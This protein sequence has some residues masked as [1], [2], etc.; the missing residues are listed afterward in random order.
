MKQKK[1]YIKNIDYFKE[2]FFKLGLTISNIFEDENNKIY[3]DY[4]LKNKEKIDIDKK[5]FNYNTFFVDGSMSKVGSNYP[6]FYYIFRSLA[7]SPEM[8]IK[9]YFYDIFSPLLKEDRALF[10]EKLKKIEGKEETTSFNISSIS[11]VEEFLRYKIMA[12]LEIEVAKEAMNYLKERDFIFMDGSLT[13]FEGE[14]P[15]EFNELKKI[16]FEKGIFLCGIIEDIGSKTIPFVAQENKNI[17]VDVGDRELLIGTLGINEMLHIENP[18]QK[19]N[20]SITFLRLSND[21][22]PISFDLP[23]NISFLYKEVSSFLAFITERYGRGIPIFR[24]MA[25]DGVKL[26]DEESF[27][28]SK[29]FIKE[30]IIERFFKMKRWLRWKIYM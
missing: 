18:P 10:E 8:D 19:E 17:K 4:I 5:D 20:Y 30:E 12:N 3:I 22:T 24:D 28:I 21:P 15:K 29:N 27:L 16:A 14:N 9:I 7:F 26:T 2:K 13:H 25:H 6:N 1:E 23:R 11:Y